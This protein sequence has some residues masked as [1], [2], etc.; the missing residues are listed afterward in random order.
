MGRYYPEYES[1][2]DEEDEEA[3]AQDSLSQDDEDNDV[4]AR[5]NTQTQTHS[6]RNDDFDTKVAKTIVAIHRK[7][8]L[9]TK[10]SEWVEKNYTHLKHLYDLSNLSC[11][12]S[13]FYTCIYDTSSH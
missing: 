11:S 10:F 9:N 12:E 3:N 2:S 8:K 13:D 5:A 6:E 7:T 4:S 1:A